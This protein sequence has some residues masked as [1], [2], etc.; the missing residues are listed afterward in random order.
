MHGSIRIS[1]ELSLTYDGGTEVKVA[2]WGL[3]EHARRNLIPS[4][5]SCDNIQLAG[6]W[7]RSKEIRDSI[8][9]S[10]KSKSYETE[11]DLLSDQSVEAVIISSPTGLHYSH[12]NMAIESGKDVWVEKSLT[13]EFKQSE[14]L[15]KS[16]ENRN[17]QVYELF[18]FLFH[19]QFK[20]IEEIISSGMI[21]RVISLNAKFGFPHISPDNFR[22]D[23]N[24]GGGSLLDAGCYTVAAAHK[25]LGPNP[26]DIH[27]K[28]YTDSGY[29]VDTSGFAVLSYEDESTAILQWGFGHSYRNEIEIWGTEG[30]LLVERAFSKPEGLPTKIK[31]DYQSGKSEL[32]EIGPCNHFH[33]MFGELSTSSQRAATIGRTWCLDQ[34]RL[35]Y[36][37][38]NSD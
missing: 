21:G 10:T 2:V 36:R 28:Q 24:L 9:I 30:H 16:A 12:A 35:L 19:P 17:L 1:G 33:A 38:Y 22:Y 25:I 29:E 26:V 37:I 11:S 20:A 8:S 18:M 31:V 23:R 14:S 7:S 13:T 34:S 6:V 27:C 5:A 4:L 15:I 32:V 3:G